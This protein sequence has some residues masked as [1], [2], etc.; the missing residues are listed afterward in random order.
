WSSARKPRAACSSRC[1]RPRWKRRSKPRDQR[2][3]LVEGRWQAISLFRVS[4]FLLSPTQLDPRSGE[5]RLVG[6]GLVIAAPMRTRR[7]L[8]RDLTPRDARRIAMLAS[9]WDVA[10]MT[11][12]IPHPYSEQ[13]AHEWISDLAEGEFVQGIIHQNVLVG[14][15]GYM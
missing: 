1:D 14:I 9:D 2:R 6:A 8:L 12:R 15:C 4:K 11:G 3:W 7:L 13:L 10:R 5:K